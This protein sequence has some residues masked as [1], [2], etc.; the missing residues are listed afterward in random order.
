MKIILLSP[1]GPLYRHRGGIFKK[2]LRYAPL[3]LTTL[4]ALVPPELHAEVEILD[5][6]I[7]EVNIDRVEA[8][9]VGITSTTGNSIRAYELADRLRARGIPVVM[10]GPHAT[11][12]PEDAQPHVDCVVVGY[13]E[14]TWPELLRDFLA[15]QMKPRYVMSPNISLANRPFPKR[16]LIKKHGYI[17]THVFESQR[18]CIHSCDFCVAPSAWGNRPFYKPVEDVIADIRQH[19]NKRI[20][21]IDLNLI[22]D[23]EYASKL[24]EALIPLRVDWFG[25]TT[26]LIYHD[27]HLLDLAARSGCS[28]LLIGFESISKENQKTVRKGFN[29]PDEYRAIVEALHWRN[30]TLMACFTFGL[31]NDTPDVF[32]DTARFA[33]QA[34]IDL[35]RY[36]IVTP[37][38]GTSLFRRLESEERIL[39]KNWELYD[40]Q[41]VVFQPKQMT[42]QELYAGHERAW[43]YT[44][45]ATN[46]FKRF[47]GSRIQIP[48]WW[49]TNIGY[50]FYAHHLREFY[51]CDTMMGPSLP[52]KSI[53][54]GK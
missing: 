16:E 4:A 5:E 11:L 10:G 28:G 24:F 29:T 1:K 50:R 23:K 12:V 7:E 13:A 26:T 3:T 49:V 20:L 33:V 9:L 46:M 2:N 38:P 32:M 34:N 44:Y 42:V 22:N 25:L 15:G 19:Y 31:D 39:T 53:Q 47:L 41:H 17:T 35:P 48:V 18:S 27:E 14:D 40:A 52:S 30:I 8:D 37:F 54:A 45:S 21:F 6:G 43:K 36:A 51:N